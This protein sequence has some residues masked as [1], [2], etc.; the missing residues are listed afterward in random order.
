[1]ES[2]RARTLANELQGEKQRAEASLAGLCAELRSGEVQL[3]NAYVQ[4]SPQCAELFA[5]WQ[6]QESFSEMCCESGDGNRIAALVIE[7]LASVLEGGFDEGARTAKTRQGVAGRILSEYLQLLY[8]YLGTERDQLLKACLRLLAGVSSVS[9][10]MSSQLLRTFNFAHE[11]FARLSQRRHQASKKDKALPGLCDVGRRRPPKAQFAQ[12]AAGATAAVPVKAM[13]W[14]TQAKAAE[15]RPPAGATPAE[16]ARH[17]REPSVTS[18]EE[19]EDRE[20]AATGD[21]QAL[22]PASRA[23]AYHFIQP[24]PVGV[25]GGRIPEKIPGEAWCAGWCGHICTVARCR[26]IRKRCLLFRGNENTDSL[27]PFADLA[28]AAGAGPD[29][30]EYLEARSLNRTATLGLGRG[31]RLATVEKDRSSRSGPRPGPTT[32]GH[33]GG[34]PPNGRRRPGGHGGLDGGEAVGYPDVAGMKEDLTNSFEM[35]G[36]IRRGPGWRPRSDGRVLVVEEAKLGRVVGPMRPPDGWNIRTTALLDTP[37]RLQP[38]PPGQVFVAAS[39]P[40]IQEDEHGKVKA[41]A[42]GGVGRRPGGGEH[43]GVRPRHAERIPAVAGQAPVALETF[44]AGAAGV[45]L[46]FHLAMCFGAAASVWHFNRT[47]DALQAVQRILLWIIAGHFVDDFNGVDMDEVADSAFQ[48]MADFLDLELLG[49]QT[50]P[51]KARRGYRRLGGRLLTADAEPS[52]RTSSPEW[53]PLSTTGR[54]RRSSTSRGNHDIIPGG[55]GWRSSTTSLASGHSPWTKGY[56]KD[57]AVN[58]ILA[59]FWSTAALCE[60]LPDF[61]RIPS[62][63]NVSDAVS[64]ASRDNLPHEDA[65]R[66][67]N[68]LLKSTAKDGVVHRFQSLKPLKPDL[69]AEAEVVVMLLTL[70]IHHQ[71]AE[72]YADLDTLA[73]N[74]VGK[75][76]DLRLRRE[77]VSKSALAKELEKLQL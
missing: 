20:R 51:S 56:G 60:W 72:I 64:P 61:R 73:N 57:G 28:A 31:S 16:M 67:V 52:W 58:G 71:A 66:A 41:R 63:A 68:R 13:V 33:P 47:A 55:G 9:Q 26:A 23:A 32:A 5:L 53:S 21:G 22:R 7:T 34:D 12:E 42:C 75:L 46:W 15:L 77:R 38:P 44:V 25:G 45:T 40:V 65:K 48:S 18:L 2:E 14:T 27:T 35:I 3:L 54:R 30:L 59:A 49:L 62:K 24:L 6:R 70:T 8:R 76:I 43:Q 36:E 19:L 39:F 74:C 17:D 11:G 69:Q 4:L 50:K 1:M 10:S 37:G 29:M